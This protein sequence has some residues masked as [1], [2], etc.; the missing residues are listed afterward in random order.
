MFL[1]RLSKQFAKRLVIFWMSMELLLTIFFNLWNRLPHY[2]HSTVAQRFRFRAS[3]R[4]DFGGF[5]PCLTSV[6]VFSEFT[7]ATSNFQCL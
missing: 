6:R 2:L 4:K 5:V 7:R 3:N 1:V